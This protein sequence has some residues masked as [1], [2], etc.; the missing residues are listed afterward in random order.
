[1]ESR[2]AA[3]VRSP[4]WIVAIAASAGGIPAIAEVLSSLPTD[5]PAAVLVL[6][7]V[8]ARRSATMLPEIL[9]RNTR[10]VVE[11]AHD[12]D[13]LSAGHV[14]VAP[15]NFHLTV[16]R[17][18]RIALTS[19]EPVHFLRPAA[20][21]LFS[22]VAASYGDHAIAVVLTGTGS[23]GALGAA[24]VR[25]A[26]GIVIAQDEATSQYFSMP[27][28]AAELAPADYVLPIEG[29]SRKLIFLTTHDGN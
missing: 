13:L 16:T 20:D 15:P 24:L 27:R 12:K 28:A 1:M 9:A 11:V 5:L 18:E 4:T 2:V 23:D 29:I 26:G 21:V 17:A 3:A 14:Y 6:L 7:H 10:L 25:K 19:A 8:E 22:S